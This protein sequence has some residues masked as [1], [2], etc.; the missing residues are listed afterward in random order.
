MAKRWTTEEKQILINSRN[1]GIP[2]SEITLERSIASMK[3]TASKYIKE[4]L[5]KNCH[6]EYKPWTEAEDLHLIE[7]RA[8]KTAYAVIEK[9]LGRSSSSVRKRASILSQKGRMQ[10]RDHP[11]CSFNTKPEIERKI[12]DDEE[13]LD[14]VRKYR[15]QD[16]LNYNRMSNEPSSG[17]IIKRFGSWTAAVEASG[18]L[19]KLGGF[20]K[21]K[22]TTLYLVS[23]GQFYKIGITQRTVSDRLRG[24][25][26]YE[27][28]GEL[29]LEFN[30]AWEIER[31][32]LKIVEPYKVHGN[33]PNGNTECFY[34]P[35]SILEPYFT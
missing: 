31:E 35:L 32:L 29:E 19:R 5:I 3:S 20:D 16:N 30:E 7:L 10:L 34:G 26:K 14:L 28:L 15:T 2:Y 21:D 8:N 25:P 6:E 9:I 18:I 22:L 4:G 23:F 24:F 11:A 1:L 12:W 33:L 17:P 13:L 27:V